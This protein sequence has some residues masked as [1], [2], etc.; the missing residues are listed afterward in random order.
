MADKPGAL[1]FSC[2]AVVH[3]WSS[4]F[5]DQ[6]VLVSRWHHKTSPDRHQ[7]N[8]SATLRE[9]SPESRMCPQCDGRSS[10]RHVWNSAS[11]M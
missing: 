5:V 1:S 8:D 11:E 9:N 2:V 4:E 10:D 6:T 7:L 3:Q